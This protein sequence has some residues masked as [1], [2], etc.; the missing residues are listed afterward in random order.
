QM[1]RKFEHRK[2]AAAAPQA[3]WFHAPFPLRRWV[4]RS[5]N[6][7]QAAIPMKA[8]LRAWIVARQLFR[9]AIPSRKTGSKPARW[10]QPPVPHSQGSL[11]RAILRMK[12]RALPR[13]EVGETQHLPFLR[14][15][16]AFRDR[17]GQTKTLVVPPQR[18]SLGDLPSAVPK[19]V[20]GERSGFRQ[21]PAQRLWARRKSLQQLR[22][23]PLPTEIRRKSILVLPRANQ[24]LSAETPVLK[25]MQKSF[26]VA[27]PQIV[28]SGKRA[29][30]RLQ[31]AQAQ[32]SS[33]EHFRLSG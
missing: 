26:E 1:G 27:V 28:G 24:L 31:R 7:K 23:R 6:G 22:L 4:A 15:E 11:D 3:P 2:S 32:R 12:G 10:I 9:E 18:T 14:S 17:L 16:F 20:L 29:A 30:A 19:A 25:L 8:L 21:K 5:A 33:R 13:R